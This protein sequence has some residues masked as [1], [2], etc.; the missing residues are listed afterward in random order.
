MTSYEVI[1]WP[2]RR[3]GEP[4][5]VTTV[6]AGSAQEAM[7]RVLNSVGLPGATYVEVRMADCLL[8]WRW[9]L[10]ILLSGRRFMSLR[11]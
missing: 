5:I 8:L 4:E 11:Q 7:V 1:V 3:T 2:Q 9:R 10:V 6:E